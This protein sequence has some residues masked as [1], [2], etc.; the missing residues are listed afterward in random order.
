M[1]VWGNI[2]NKVKKLGSSSRSQS[3]RASSASRDDM[4][5]DSVRRPSI[6]FQEEE[7]ASSSLAVPRSRLKIHV[8]IMVDQIV[9]RIDYERDALELLKKQSFGHAKRFETD[10]LTMTG[11]RQDMKRAF[12]AAGWANF[13][14]ITE[15]GSH[16]LTMEFLATLHVATIGTETK[17]HFH[18][19]NEFFEMKPKDFST[20]LGFS[21]YDH[22]SWWSEI[23]DE[24]I[25][26]YF[27]S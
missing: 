16:L 11:L 14:D 27:Y 26:H 15:P 3:S 8:L 12:T 21:D 25:R 10:F 6:S 7:E 1:S 13:T 2:R 24:P 17:I 23:S 4:S 5:V 18:L 22:S 20:A 9:V 19:F